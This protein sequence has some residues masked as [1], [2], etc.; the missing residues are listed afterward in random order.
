MTGVRRVAITGLGVCTPLGFSVSE[1]WANL[2]QGSCG[3]SKTLDEFSFLP[4]HVFGSID[5]RKLE[6]QKSLVESEVYKSCVLDISNDW[7]SV[8]RASALGIIATCEAFKQVKWKANSG[9]RAGVCF[10]VGLDGPNEVMNTSSGI[11]SK[12]YST[13]GPHA[14]TRILGNMPAGIISR[15]WGLRGPCMTVNTACASG[16]HCIGEGFRMIQNNEAD[17]VVTGACES[18]LNA[19]IIAAFCRLRA[20]C[21]QFNDTPEKASRPF[22]SLRKGFVLSEGA[23]TVVLQAWPPPDSFLVESFIETPKPIAEVIGFGRSGD[24][25]HLVAPDAT[26][27]GALRS[28]LNAFKDSKLEHFSQIGHINCHATSTPVGDLTEL[29]AIAQI[30]GEYFT[31]QYHTPVVINSIKGHLGHCLAAA[32]AIETVYSALSVNQNRICGNLNLHNPISI[33]EL[34]EV[35]KSNSS[36]STNISFNEKCIDLFKNYAV[37]PRHDE[38]QVAWPDSHRRIV[39]TNSFGFGGTNGTLL[40][41]EWTD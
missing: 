31:P 9:Y 12:K 15:I 33:Y 13:I 37:L 2:L 19:W 8:S 41:S 16:L 5:D 21:T 25:H 26:G 20:L 28:M 36:S 3:I 23:A 35:L 11:L 10:G 24:A 1:L 27:N 34:M 18:P 17:L 4:S 39:M 40:I 22:D 30:F 6:E 38:I 7:R 29:S 14:L 32:G